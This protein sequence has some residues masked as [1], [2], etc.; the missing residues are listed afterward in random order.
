M[1]V[2]MANQFGRGYPWLNCGQ[3]KMVASNLSQVDGRTTLIE[4]ADQL[5]SIRPIEH[6]ALAEC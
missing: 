2:D 4:A 1:S 5:L 3:L 6:L